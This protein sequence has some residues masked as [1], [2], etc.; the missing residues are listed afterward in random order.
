M[1]MT[2]PTTCID[3][4]GLGLME[5]VMTFEYFFDTE[6]FGL[7]FYWNG[8]MQGERVHPVL[9]KHRITLIILNCVLAVEW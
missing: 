4:L 6:T 1:K 2:R 3:S 5:R 8:P 9:A 7:A